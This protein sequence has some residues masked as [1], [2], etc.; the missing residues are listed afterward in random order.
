MVELYCF[1]RYWYWYIFTMFILSCFGTSA[2]GGLI[3]PAVDGNISSPNYPSN[4]RRLSNCT[5]VI[6]SPDPGECR[7]QLQISLLYIYKII[8]YL[9]HFSSKLY[10]TVF[11]SYR[12]FY[13]PTGCLFHI[14]HLLQVSALSFWELL[15]FFNKPTWCGPFFLPMDGTTITPLT[16]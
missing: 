3:N 4:Y 9:R 8:W 11:L 16:E 12:W 1:M 7:Q 13:S 10:I 15:V 5:W 2:C 14:R 6:E